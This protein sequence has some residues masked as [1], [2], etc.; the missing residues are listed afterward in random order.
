VQLTPSAPVREAGAD[1]ACGCGFAPPE[2][3]TVCFFPAVSHAPNWSKGLL[4]LGIVAGR[5]RSWLAFCVAFYGRRDRRLVGPHRPL[6]P[7][8]WG[9]LFLWNKYYLDH[10][11]ERIIVRGVAYP[12]AKRRLLGQPAGDRPGGRRQRPRHPSRRRVHVPQ[13]RPA[14]VD[15]AVNASGTVASETGHALQ[16]VQSGKVNQYGALIFGAAAVA[17]I[18]LVL[19]NV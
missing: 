17:A 15:G 9:Y 16:P 11:Y 12:I 19:V 3:G 14:V 13:H 8:R 6:R 5:L 18:V 7:A 4:A 1:G 2:A 10:L